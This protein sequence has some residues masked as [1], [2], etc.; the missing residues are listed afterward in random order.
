MVNRAMQISLFADKVEFSRQVT[1]SLKW[2]PDVIKS[3]GE[4][5]LVSCHLLFVFVI[6]AVF[7]VTF[8]LFHQIAS[9]LR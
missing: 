8:N 3:T 7:A 2:I 4:F 5:V 9:F 1:F 6:A